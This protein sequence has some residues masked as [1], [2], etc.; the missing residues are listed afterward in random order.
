MLL[1]SQKEVTR[2]TPIYPGSNF[3]WGEATHNLTRPLQDLIIDS[4]LICHAGQ[5]ELNIVQQA[6][7]LDRIRELLGNRPLIVNSWYRPSHINVRVGGS[8]YSKHLYG[9]ATDIRSNYL[10]AHK[11]Y[12]LLDRVWHGG[13]GRYYSFVHVDED[14]QKRRWFA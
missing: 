8:K 11:I 5:I 12:Q 9:L 4:K 7:N 3:T 10:S 13:L 6:K 1:P 14:N 2:H